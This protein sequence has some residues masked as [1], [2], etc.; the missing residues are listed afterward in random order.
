MINCRKRKF[1]IQDVRN[2]EKIP[3]VTKGETV[4]LQ[5]KKL[6]EKGDGIAYFDKYVILIP[7]TKVKKF[8]KIKITR[9]LKSH[10]FGK[11]L[12]ELK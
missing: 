8:Y 3:P 9:I 4:I 6:G 11:V 12:E 5:V 10:G 7:N 2:M 1:K